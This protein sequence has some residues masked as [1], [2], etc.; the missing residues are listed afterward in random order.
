MM[1]VKNMTNEEEKKAIKAAENLIDL[2]KY[3][4]PLKYSNEENEMLKTLLNYIT[5]LENMHQ[6]EYNEH[7]EKKRQN[8][9][10]INNE[11]ILRKK[12]EDQSTI[13]DYLEKQNKKKCTSKQWDH[14]NAEKMGCEGCYYNSDVIGDICLHC[15]SGKPAYCEDCY[16][17][18]ISENIKL[19]KHILEGG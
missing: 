4:S 6:K 12:I 5:K 18:L 7:M 3:E 9:V 2:Y 14:C 1:E 8:E 17:Q 15:G 11:L 10:L 13:I 19:Q 16:Q